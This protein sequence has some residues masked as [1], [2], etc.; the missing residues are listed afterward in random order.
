LA[1]FGTKGITYILDEPGSGD[2]ALKLRYTFLLMGGIGMT[3]RW[4]EEEIT[5]EPEGMAAILAGFI[6]RSP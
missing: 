2:E 5:Q 4:F 1:S 3:K 6:R